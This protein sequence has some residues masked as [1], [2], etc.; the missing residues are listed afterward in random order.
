[1]D[2]LVFFGAYYA[3]KVAHLI[4]TGRF[5]MVESMKRKTVEMRGT[6][7]IDGPLPRFR[8]VRYRTSA[9]LIDVEE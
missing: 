5:V 6:S 4:G 9:T 2:V 7:L 3:V 1:V 8:R